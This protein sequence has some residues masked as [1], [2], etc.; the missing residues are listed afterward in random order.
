MTPW[1]R[2]AL[3]RVLTAEVATSRP[4]VMLKCHSFP[5]DRILAMK[6]LAWTS[7]LGRLFELTGQHRTTAL[8]PNSCSKNGCLS[9][10]GD[11]A[12]KTLLYL[13]IYS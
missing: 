12:I 5:N 2:T 10:L 8:S 11:T 1:Q 3:M 6:Q 9:P 13:S 7:T 4:P